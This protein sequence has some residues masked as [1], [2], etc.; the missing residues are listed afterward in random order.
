MS[1]GPA[2]SVLLTN[3]SSIYAG[4]EYYVLVLASELLARGHRVVVSCRPDNLLFDKCAAKK[5][6]TEPVDFPS[7]GKL[8]KNVPLLRRIIERNGIEIVHTNTNYDRTAGAM[9]A[10]LAG[11]RHVANIH[12]FHS[13][14]HNLT[15]RLRNRWWTDRFIT[16]GEGATDILV[17]EDGIPREKITIVRLGL[18]PDANVRSPELRARARAEFGIREGETLVGN[19][20]RL[21]PFKGQEYLLRSFASVAGAHPRVKLMIVGD[22]EL[23]GALRRQAAELSLGDRVIFTGFRDDIPS[24]YSAMDVYAH[25][26]VEGGGETFPFAVLQAL[27]YGLPTVVTDVGEVGA[28]VE[29]GVTGFAVPDRDERVFSVALERLLSDRPLR[30]SMGKKGREL[31]LKKFT[32]AVMASAVEEVY[33]TIR[34]EARGGKAGGEG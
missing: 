20:G 19:V 1:G 12:S 5:I 32:S 24:M 30:D 6:P 21:V 17:N 16:L 23:D 4:G 11:A 18:E 27:A 3:A 26:S 13:I 14:S 10:R 28:M 15:H 8:L 7:R 2:R 29:E 34:P 9:A 22:G 25:S 33:L 31:M